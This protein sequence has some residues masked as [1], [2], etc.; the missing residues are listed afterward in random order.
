M[1]TRTNRPR[2]LTDEMVARLEERVAKLAPVALNTE[3]VLYETEQHLTD[4]HNAAAARNDQAGMTHAVAVWD[5]TQALADH[6]QQ[7]ARTTAAAMAAMGKLK[8]HRSQLLGELQALTQAV[9]EA[10]T[11]HPLVLELVE[12]VEELVFSN[13]EPDQPYDLFDEWIADGMGLTLDQAGEVR[14]MITGDDL[15][16]DETG[17]IVAFMAQMQR[18]IYARRG[19]DIPEYYDLSLAAAQAGDD[20]R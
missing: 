8:E 9:Q 13:L 5:R 10:D 3:K 1:S 18:E 6:V 4:L 7:H 19:S 20:G 16:R 2:Q 15:T 17:R 11:E 14:E 12:S